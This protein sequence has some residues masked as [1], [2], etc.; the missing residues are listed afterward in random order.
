MHSSLNVSFFVCACISPL[1]SRLSRRPSRLSPLALL[2]TDHRWARRGHCRAVKCP[3][4]QII[5]NENSQN[6]KKRSKMSFTSIF[7]FTVLSYVGVDEARA[8]LSTVSLEWQKQVRI[9]FSHKPRPC[10][11]C[12][13][14]PS[15]CPRKVV[16]WFL[17]LRE[18]A[19]LWTT[20]PQYGLGH[21]LGTLLRRIK[22]AIDPASDPDTGWSRRGDAARSCAAFENLQVRVFARARALFC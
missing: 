17:R 14:H 16:S 13:A 6:W 19:R 3:K 11:P 8:V 4:Y 20:M 18:E 10:H 7:S 12:P 22:R 5:E 15:V 2:L 1:A 21:R 9:S